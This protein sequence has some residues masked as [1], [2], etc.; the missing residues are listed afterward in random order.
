MVIYEKKICVK[1]D[2]TGVQI[3]D[4]LEMVRLSEEYISENPEVSYKKLRI[5]LEE[6]R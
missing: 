5:I 1:Q 2:V 3:L 4:L 6:R